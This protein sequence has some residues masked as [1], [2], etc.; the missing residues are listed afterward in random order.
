MSI[1]HTPKQLNDLGDA[2]FYGNGKEKN[3]ELA[4]TYYKKA[5]DLNNPVGY[6]NVGKYFIEKGQYKEALEYLSKAKDLGYTKAMIQ[7]SDMYLNGLGTRK[8]K[9][10]AFKNL[11]V[12]VEANDIYAFH[13]L[14]IFYLKGIGCRKDEKNAL[15]YFELSA[16]SDVARGMY[17]LGSLYLDAKK[18]KPDY[19][20]GFFW[21]DKAAVLGDLMAIHRLIDLYH[22]SHAFLK[23]KSKLY[24][25]EMEFY[26]TELLARS[27]DE[28]A[29][30]KVAFTY[31]EGNDYTKINYDKANHYFK[32]L[33]QLDHTMGYLGL[34]LSNLYGRGIDTNYTKA[35]EYLEIAGTRGNMVA[36]NALGE[37]YRLGY[38]VEVNFQRAKDY[39]FEAAKSNET[40]ALI[41]LGLL[42][43]RKQISGAT[44]KMAFQY[45]KNAKDKGNEL[46]H[47]W[48]GIFYEKGIGTNVDLKLAEQEYK[49]AIDAGNEGAKYKY[50]QM[51][52]ENT[53]RK[54][55]SNKKRNQLYLEIKDLLIEYINSP[56]TSEVNTTYSMVMLGDLFRHEA[57][58]LRS[59]KISR[60]YY[61]SAAMKQHAKALVQ[62]FHILRKKEPEVAFNYLKEAC[63]HPV[64]GESFYVMAM[65]YMEGSEFTDKD[66]FK[67]KEYFGKAAALNYQPAKEKL[68]MM[69]N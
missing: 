65:L 8:S 36:M 30:V 32:D 68:G 12:A 5:A 20:N 43:Y 9:K 49:Q 58:S 63:K 7:L 35:K 11:M 45:M 34:G 48:L 31:Y 50:A 56:N 19:K 59:D 38:G 1:N 42:H 21:L 39:Y 40:N 27:M 64:D 33:L 57:F 66:D 47:Y 54:K 22:D 15:H 60:Y 29:L 2:Y 16:K 28:D 25:Q 4:F 44:H 53:S 6:F 62:M 51:L 24:L 3:I 37:M 26:Y 10:K 17:H 52:Y 61:E 69:V 46:S 18:I 14:G 23:K 13:Q 67:A 41:N 55:L